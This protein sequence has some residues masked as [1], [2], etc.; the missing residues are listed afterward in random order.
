MAT[1]EIPLTPDP[2]TLTIQLGSVN[3]KLELQWGYSNNTWLMHL[4]TDTGIRLLSSIPLVAGTNLLEP[5]AYMNLGGS[6]YAQTEGEL[7]VAP[8]YENLGTLGR[9]FFVTP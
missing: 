6:L 5:Y 2:Q 7:Y 3:Y 9:V 8:T 4:S 1:Y